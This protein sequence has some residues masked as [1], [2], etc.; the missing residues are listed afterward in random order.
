M[1]VRFKK[2][3]KT[4]IEVIAGAYA[5]EKK[6]KIIV[7]KAYIKD[8]SAKDEYLN[9]IRLIKTGTMLQYY[10]ENRTAMNAEKE[11]S[12]LVSIKESCIK[13]LDE[14]QRL[15]SLRNKPGGYDRSISPLKS[16][17]K[18]IDNRLVFLG[19]SKPVRIVDGF[20]D[21]LKSAGIVLALKA[22]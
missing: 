3:L 4:G 17:I 12:I 8:A 1:D 6:G 14:N 19:K 11:K 16:L 13:Y 15:W 20:L 10:I 7:C 2:V 18:Q 5:C 9:A 21:K 22:M